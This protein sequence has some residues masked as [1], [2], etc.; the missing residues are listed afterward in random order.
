M[1][2]FKLAA[3]ILASDFARLGEQ[4]HEAEAA[5]ADW[6]LVDVWMDTS[7]Q[8]SRSVRQLSPRCAASPS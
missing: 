3:S 8:I 5:G 1:T 4:A 6:L 2:T 7:C